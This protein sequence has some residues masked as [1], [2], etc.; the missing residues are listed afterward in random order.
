LSLFFYKVHSLWLCY[1]ASKCT[2]W[3]NELVMCNSIRGE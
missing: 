3:I 1:N 2:Q